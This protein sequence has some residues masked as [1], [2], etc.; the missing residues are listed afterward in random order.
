MARRAAALSHR[1]AAYPRIRECASDGA[2]AKSG[3]NRCGDV[4]HARRASMRPHAAV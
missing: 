2:F 1:P 4:A 3:R